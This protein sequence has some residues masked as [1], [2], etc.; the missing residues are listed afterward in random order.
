MLTDDQLATEL[1]RIA[2]LLKMGVS[3]PIAGLSRALLHTAIDHIGMEQKASRRKESAPGSAAEETYSHPQTRVINAQWSEQTLSSFQRGRFWDPELDLSIRFDAR[4]HDPRQ[5]LPIG[6][7][8]SHISY[9]P[10]VYSKLY[11][12]KPLPKWH[13]YL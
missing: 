4:S 7:D 10:L 3:D 2:T 6:I 1:I 11:T 8:H 12:Q 9:D 13:R 5:I